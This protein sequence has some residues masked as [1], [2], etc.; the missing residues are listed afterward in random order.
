[1]ILQ[2]HLQ[3]FMY[4]VNSWANQEIYTSKSLTKQYDRIHTAWKNRQLARV[5]KLDKTIR[6][7]KVKLLINSSM[8]VLVQPL[9]LEYFLPYT[10]A[11]IVH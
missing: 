1:M 6:L 9:V 3:K 10:K 7:V 8:I 4:R 5:I 2:V 11:I